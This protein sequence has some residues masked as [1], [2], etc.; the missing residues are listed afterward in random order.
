MLRGIAR[1]RQR[2]DHDR[3]CPAAGQRLSGVLRRRAPYSV[4]LVIA[5][6]LG[7]CGVFDRDQ[8][9]PVVPRAVT[10]PRI[11]V[12]PFENPGGGGDGYFAAGMTDEIAER[13]AAVAELIVISDSGGTDVDD[14]ADAVSRIGNELGAEYALSGAVRRRMET[15]AGPYL[16]ADVQLIRVSDGEV[17]WSEHYDRPQ[18]SVFAVQADVAIN[19]VDVLGVTVQPAAQRLLEIQSTQ[20]MDAYEAYLRGLPYRWS[21]ELKELGLAGD[22]FRRAVE[23]D[24]E[25]AA[26]YVALSE[27]YSLMFHFRYDRSPQC[28]ANANAAAHRAIELQPDLPEGHRALGYYYYWGQRNYE[29]A[30]AEFSQAAAGRPNDPL[31]ISSIGIVLRR[32][33]R[34]QEA[35][36]AFTR[37]SQLDPKSD[38]NA[39]DLASTCG[40]MRRYA[41]GV[42]HCRRAIDLAPDDIFPYVFMAKMMRTHDGSIE[43]AREVLEE[44]P[45]KDPGQQG[46]FRFEQALYERD[47]D[48]AIAWLAPTEELISD[49]ISEEIIPRSLAECESRVLAGTPATSVSACS[50]ARS[51]LERAR[52]ISPVDPAVHAALGWTYA[53]LGERAS[54]I[55]SGERAVEILP[56]SA[57]ALAGHSYLVRLAKIYAWAGEPYA[58]VKTIEKALATPGWLSTATLKLDP[59]WDPI[60]TDPRFQELLRIHTEGD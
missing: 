53:L 40:R 58:A 22:S 7:A 9:P 24:P 27:N 43:G 8:Q 33:G 11:I 14:S 56:V 6:F 23:L 39:V 38:I 17:L 44:M 13:L 57:D 12:L 28:L 18:S 45:D 47:Y 4:V 34:W 29:Q 55:A 16:D 5:S 59:D 20:S 50:E 54:A 3:R 25:F 10:G 52:E 1:I 49:P 2:R 26:A 21:F 51:S 41:E 36:D 31:I 15:D 30:L 42:E 46:F 35:I 48:A 19:V 32:Q 37:V 60:R